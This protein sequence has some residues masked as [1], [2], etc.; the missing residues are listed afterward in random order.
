MALR[1]PAAG[2]R[3]AH[4]GPVRPDRKPGATGLRDASDQG[5]SAG[6]RAAASG[7]RRRTRVTTEVTTSAP[8][9]GLEPAQQ[10]G[11]GPAQLARPGG[12]VDGHDEPP[13]LDRRPAARA[14]AT[15]VP[16]SSSHRSRMVRT[17]STGGAPR[18]AS[19]RSSDSRQRHG[20]GRLVPVVRTAA[21]TASADDPTRRRGRATT[22]SSA[23]GRPAPDSIRRTRPGTAPGGSAAG[24]GEDR[25][26]GREVCSSASLRSGR[27]R[28]TRRRAAAPGG[29]PSRDGHQPVRGQAQRQGQG[30]L[31]ALRGVG[32]GRQAVEHDVELVAVRTDRAH[33]PAQ[34][35]GARRRRARRP[36]PS[37]RQGAVVAEHDLGR[38]AGRPAS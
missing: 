38:L 31:L 27:A 30:P 7:Q 22:A 36:G 29:V 18:P 9:S 24:G 33:A 2:D 15:P 25:L 6:Q 11:F 26:A 17:W 13:V 8:S 4:A 14:S 28:R 1:I 20:V 32:P 16:T 23:L 10:V 12:V 19:T 5:R 21:T 37:A 35:V 34:V 3:T